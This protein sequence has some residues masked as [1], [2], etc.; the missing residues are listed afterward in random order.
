MEWIPETHKGDLQGS[1]DYY[2]NSHTA[3]LDRKRQ[4]ENKMKEGC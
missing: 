2:A 1:W 4:K 3:M